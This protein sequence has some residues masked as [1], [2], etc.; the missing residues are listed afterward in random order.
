MKSTLAADLRGKCL[1]KLRNFYVRLGQLPS[2]FRLAHVPEKLSEVPI[3]RGL[4]RDVWKGRCDDDLVVMTMHRFS[5]TETEGR[6][7][8]VASSQ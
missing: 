6:D 1:E 7:R 2:S 5:F 4:S 3:S 8:Q